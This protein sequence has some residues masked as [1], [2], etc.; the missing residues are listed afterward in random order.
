MSAWRSLQ[1]LNTSP[2]FWAFTN[3]HCSAPTL[4]F[5][6]QDYFPHIYSHCFQKLAQFR[7]IFTSIFEVFFKAFQYIQFYHSDKKIR[8]YLP[9]CVPICSSS[10]L[11]GRL[12]PNVEK[13]QCRVC[14]NLNLFSVKKKIR[15]N[16][17]S[18]QSHGLYR[19]AQNDSTVLGSKIS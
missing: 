8:I 18:V 19:G 13:H 2:V 5:F 10:V 1:H 7:S 15:F 17:G 6:R 9:G 3:L 4:V 14:K 12:A 16:L 11:P